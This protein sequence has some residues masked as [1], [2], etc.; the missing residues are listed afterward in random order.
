MKHGRERQA[1]R[2]TNKMCKY[3]LRVTREKEHREQSSEGKGRGGRLTNDFPTQDLITCLR[4][5]P[6]MITLP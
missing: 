6:R 4:A 3:K 2:E 1:I 5:K